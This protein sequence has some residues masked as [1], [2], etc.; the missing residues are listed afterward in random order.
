MV[1][2][3]LALIGMAETRAVAHAL[4]VGMA[5]LAIATFMRW[6]GR[7]GAAAADLGLQVGIVP[8]LAA[9]I[10]CRVMPACTPFA[11]FAVCG[12]A[13]LLAAMVLGHITTQQQ[14]PRVWF[15]A[16]TVAALTTS[17]GCIAFGVG[18]A[19]GTAAA[20]AAALGFAVSTHR[21]PTA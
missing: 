13:G 14:D 10:L 19:V 18:V 20:T 2:V 1:I 11:A 7:S 5:L 16:A 17:L 6:T 4:I 15:G 21:K 3:P 12:T 8:M 9:L